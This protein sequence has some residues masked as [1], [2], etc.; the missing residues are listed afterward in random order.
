MH[1]ATLQMWQKATGP[2]FRTTFNMQSEVDAWL[3]RWKGSQ[4]GVASSQLASAIRAA[5][6]LYI[7]RNHL[8]EEALAAASDCGDLTNF[9]QPAGSRAASI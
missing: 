8:V 6:P 5:N 9:E 1:G 7:P 4:N 3:E 2:S